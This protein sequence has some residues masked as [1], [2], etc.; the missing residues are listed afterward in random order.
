MS[1]AIDLTANHVTIQR[2]D[3]PKYPGT[4]SNAVK[5]SEFY[6]L[7]DNKSE[8]VLVSRKDCKTPADALA[9]ALEEMGKRYGHKFVNPPRVTKISNRRANGGS[10]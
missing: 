2:Y 8:I 9:K 1:T 7:R 6:F 5:W 4:S 10:I 3:E